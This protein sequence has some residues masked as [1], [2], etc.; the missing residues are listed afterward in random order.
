MTPTYP[1]NLWIPPFIGIDHVLTRNCTATAVGTA[2]PP[3][4]D[5]AESLPPFKCRGAVPR[6]WA[7]SMWATTV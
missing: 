4:S 3:G 2:V 6:D 5:N 1:G 7:R